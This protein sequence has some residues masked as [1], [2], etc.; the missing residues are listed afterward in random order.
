MT[1]LY[2]LVALCFATALHAAPIRVVVWDE[3]QPAAKKA[4]PN[5]IGGQIA[6]YLETLPELSV[7]SVSLNDP[8]QGLADETI[9]HCD[10]LIWWS[11]V[12]NKLVPTAK[13]LRIVQRI[14][15]GK[16][17]LIMLHSSITSK[18]FIEA[19]NERTREDAAKVI[20]AGVK[21]EYILPKV[22]KDPLPTD[23]ITP[24]VETT[25]APDGSRLARVFLP[26]CE[27]TGWHENGSPSQITTLLPEHPIARGVPRQ[28]VN[29]QTEIYLEPIHV[30]KPDAVIFEETWATNGPF[31]SGMLWEVGK[32]KVFYFRPEHET[33]PGYFNPNILRIIGNATEWMGKPGAD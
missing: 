16:M 5:F 6:S 27:I 7:K 2:Y 24:R 30:P 3:Q 10:V 31:R 20:P 13:A 22:Y 19:M 14:K 12:K 17:S 8:D 11:H 4:Y 9:D 23:P 26:I 32:G 18:V 29:P 15:E 21:V 28:F 1:K 33:F 25:N